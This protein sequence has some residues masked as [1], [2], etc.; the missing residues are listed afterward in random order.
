[1]AEWT[2]GERT[3]QPTQRRREEARRQGQVAL[4]PEVSPVAI[5]AAA[6]ALGSLGGPL[7]LGRMRAMLHASLRAVEHGVDDG[8]LPAVLLGPALL[9]AARVV[10]P[11]LVLVGVVGATAVVAQVGFAVHPALVLPK[12]GRLAGGWAR[13]W[14]GQSVAGLL[15]ALAKIVLVLAVA[16]RVVLELGHGAMAAPAMAPAELVALVGGALRTLLLVLLGPLALIGAGDWV[17]Q[18][19]RFEQSLKMSRQEVKEEQRQTEGDPQLRGRFRRAHRELVRR[20]MLADVK[21][22]DVVLTNPTHV[23]VALRYRASEGAA[24]RVVA[25]GADE[26]AQ[27]IRDAARAAGVPIVERRALARALFRTVRVGAEV[28][29]ELYKAVAEIL[30]Y[31]YTVRGVP[32]AEDR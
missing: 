11:V 13:L 27:R 7:A 15:K 12:G 22:A 4:S 3:E 23:A 29:R 6:L 26:L 30:A 24:P 20:R 18:R 28:P 21:T 5:L 1:M 25:K 19:W 32:G 2:G 8:S 9:E 31:I 14:S 16:W 10:V 17:W